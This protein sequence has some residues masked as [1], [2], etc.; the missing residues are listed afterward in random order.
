MIKTKLTLL[1]I[2]LSISLI[3]LAKGDEAP[4]AGDYNR[5]SYSLIGVA[6]S[7]HIH[8]LNHWTRSY[9]PEAKFDYNKISTKAIF[10]DEDEIFDE[11][12]YASKLGG[13]LVEYRI[14][15]QIVSTIFNRQ[16]SGEMNDSIVRHR[17]M[18]NASAEQMMD[19]EAASLGQRAILE[20]RGYRLLENSYVIMLTISDY[21]EID[22]GVSARGECNLFRL[23]LTPQLL[24]EE[25]FDR[26]WVYPDDREFVRQQK[27]GYFESY[28]FEFEHI[29]SYHIKRIYIS[30]DDGKYM[31]QLYSKLYDE[32]IN[33][34]EK[35]EDSFKVQAPIAAKHPVVAMIGEKESLRKRDRFDAYK[36]VVNS[37]GEI[38]RRRT[39]I[40]RATSVVDNQ[41]DNSLSS[42]FFPIAGY[43]IHEGD[44]LI[45][46]NDKKTLVAPIIRHGALDGYGLNLD[47]ITRLKSDGASGFAG[48]YL[49][50]A[51]YDVMALSGGTI[52]YINKSP[53]LYDDGNWAATSLGFRFGRTQRFLR[54]M[55][56]GF[57]I[58]LGCDMLWAS[59][60]RWDDDAPDYGYGLVVTAT[61]GLNLR[62]N[63]FYPLHVV[64]GADYTYLGDGLFNSDDTSSLSYQYSSMHSTLNDVG[65]DREGVGYYVGLSLAF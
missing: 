23:K 2:L 44:I 38:K 49:I 57:N 43:S 13:W 4:M 37:K 46:H 24:S 50:Y 16:P 62:V 34:L 26:C 20:D 18:Y 36:F 54:Y 64:C 31:D 27:C 39:A 19:A 59:Y 11:S 41:A 47:A 63:I 65:V 51:P 35:G 12:A 53:Q 21:A 42:E 45:Q 17:G 30:K 8:N 6:T 25:I 32:A 55:E 28:D 48:L 7:E 58:N 60:N 56:A 14:G 52:D 29:S 61:A 15:Q 40:L 10:D 1:S 3:T 5:M 22:S 33:R 9:I